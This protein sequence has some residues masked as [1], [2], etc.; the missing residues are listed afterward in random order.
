MMTISLN[1]NMGLP[2]TVKT[3]ST[4]EISNTHSHHVW[5]HQRIHHN[6]RIPVEQVS[7]KY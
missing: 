7:L 1:V 3:H 2:A 4:K 5:I 6:R